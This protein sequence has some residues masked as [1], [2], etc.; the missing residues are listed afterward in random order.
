MSARN[1]L[2][3]RRWGKEWGGSIDMARRW[4]IKC[5]EF[6]TKGSYWTAIA[7]VKRKRIPNSR[8]S[9]KKTFKAKTC[10]DARHKQQIS[11][12]WTQCTSW[13]IMFKNRV[14]ICRLSSVNG[15][16]C[17]ADNLELGALVNWKPVVMFEQS[18]WAG[19]LTVGAPGDYPGDGILCALQ[20]SNVF[21]RYADQ[22][23]VG[24]IKPHSDE[25]TG[26]S[27][28]YVFLRAERM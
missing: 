26:D 12:R 15:F 4:K 3:L 1:L 19:R 2:N 24:V 27:F 5:F 16:V 10:T 17:N 25:G 11:V 21:R 6:T 14:Q 22:N 18:R 9:Y 7:N 13:N 28:R 23:R 8:G 20:T